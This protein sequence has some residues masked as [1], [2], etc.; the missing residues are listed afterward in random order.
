MKKAKRLLIIVLA[1]IMLCSVIFVVPTSVSSAEISV[2]NTGYSLLSENQFIN[3]LNILRAKYPNGGTWSGTYYENGTAKA[4]Q[5]FGYANQ[6]LYEV[7]G[8]QFYNDGFYNKKD[9]NMGTIYAGDWVRIKTYG[10][11]NNHS[12]FI[13]KVTNDRVYFT[14]ANWSGNNGIRW[15]VSYTKAEFAQKFSYKI[16]IPGNTLTGNGITDT[17]P[18]EISNVYQSDFSSTG[19]TLHF[20]A[21]DNIGLS[22]VTIYTSV[23]GPNLKEDS[24]KLSGTRQDVSYTVKYSDFGTTTGYIHG[25]WLYDINGNKKQSP[26]IN[27]VEDRENP[28]VSNIYQDNFDDS[29]YTLHF[30][31][32]DNNSL[33]Y[34]KIFTWK[35]GYSQKIEDISVSGKSKNISYRVNYKD[36]NN[37][38]S[39]YINAVWAYDTANN[40]GVS[41]FI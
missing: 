3:K 15:D 12:I 8:V 36:F 38:K 31:L 13:T 19:Y 21:S 40:R 9:Y 32:T 37:E 18:P 20:T 26:W 29:G 35:N 33:K 10:E 34:F 41:P 2:N 24:I 27:V 14:D 11:P 28:V 39:G 7:F 22:S 23:N 17:T 16:H 6:M 1:V 4:W 5:C 25:I 30:T